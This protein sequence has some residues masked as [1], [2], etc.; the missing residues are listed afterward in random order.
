MTCRSLKVLVDSPGSANQ[1]RPNCYT[2][3]Q[4]DTSEKTPLL[5]GDKTKKSEKEPEVIGPSLIKV[6][7]KTFGWEILHAQTFKL[8]YDGLVFVL[9]ELLK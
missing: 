6:I 3:I 4:E 7:I 2:S 5:Q 1:N 8:F 9:P